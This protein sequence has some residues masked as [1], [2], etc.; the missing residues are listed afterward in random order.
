MTLR[1]AFTQ[2]GQVD[3]NMILARKSKAAVEKVLLKDYGDATLP[4]MSQNFVASIFGQ[5]KEPKEMKVKAAS[6]LVY[7][8]KWA[9]QN[10]ECKEP[11]FSYSIANFESGKE[12]SQQQSAPEEEKKPVNELK[13]AVVKPKHDPRRIRCREVVRLNEKTLKETGRWF[14]CQEA[15]KRLGLRGDTIAKAARHHEHAYKNYWAYADELKDG[16][17]EPAERK[18]KKGFGT[19]QVKKAEPTKKEEPTKEVIVPKEPDAS[20]LEIITDDQLK[21]ELQRRGYT[22]ELKKTITTVVTLTLDGK[23]ND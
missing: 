8:L 6:V 21:E 19:G 23:A 3:G 15:A 10:G 7:I 1:Q 22:G 9:A 16:N 5:S 2:W 14:S 20:S 12:G 4:M 18:Y 11:N 13:E 17:W